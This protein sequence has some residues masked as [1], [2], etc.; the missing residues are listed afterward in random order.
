MAQPGRRVGK[1]RR[2]Q[3]HAAQALCV[4]RPEQA[5][6][7]QQRVDGRAH[8]ARGA[9]AGLAQ[10]LD[11]E[12]GELGGQQ[13]RQ[14]RPQVLRTRRRKE[15][16]L[17]KRHR[18]AGA[19]WPVPAQPRAQRLIHGELQPAGRR[20][21]GR[22]QRHA[23]AAHTGGV[24]GQRG[25]P[26]DPVERAALG[27]SADVHAPGRRQ[28]EA[29]VHGPGRDD[30]RVRHRCGCGDARGRRP[31]RAQGTEQ[32]RAARVVGHRSAQVCERVVQQVLERRGQ[33]AAGGV[34]QLQRTQQLAQGGQ[35]RGC[36]ALQGLQGRGD[37]QARLG[38]QRAG[39]V[40]AGRGQVGRQRAQVSGLQ[41][42]PLARHAEHLRIDQRGAGQRRCCGGVTAQGDV[43]VELEPAQLRWHR[44]AGSA[45]G[46]GA[47]HEP[48]V[49]AA[50]FKM[51]TQPARG[52][53]G[54]AGPG[55]LHTGE[56]DFGVAAQL[57]LASGGQR[58]LEH[59]PQRQAKAVGRGQLERQAPGVALG[60]AGGHHGREAAPHR[61][62]T[63]LAKHHVHREPGARCGGR[64][65][66]RAQL[67]GRVVLCG[68]LGECG[69]EPAAD[70][71]IGVVGDVVGV[72]GQQALQQA[73]RIGG[74]GD[75]DDRQR[76]RP[77]WRA[78][79][80][81]VGHH[82]HG[83]GR[84][85]RGMA[86]CRF[87]HQHHATRHAT[88]RGQHAGQT[89]GLAGQAV[90]VAAGQTAGR[91]PAERQEPLASGRRGHQRAD[92]QRRWRETRHREVDVPRCRH[93][94]PGRGARGGHGHAQHGDWRAAEQRV[95]FECFA[96]V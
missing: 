83:L 67:A 40:E 39:G 90:F 45:A 93:A 79:G 74:R 33:A 24:E 88:K 78:Q 86:C 37:E 5:H 55:H 22:A 12:P 34:K 41:A 53:E 10:R 94:G 70:V 46:V 63:D 69:D 38:D 23:A 56:V 95:Q 21:V 62:F 59:G 77:G 20:V 7:R 31:Q 49:A 1:Q 76:H 48:A 96:Q 71:Q 82:G 30:D 8:G 61:V 91:P 44:L 3:R 81:E 92:V 9:G 52:G 80:D 85:P 14:R 28:Y 60:Q 17:V 89:L 2:R 43:D 66:R 18:G 65:G 11:A 6:G 32:G 75:I 50:E 19:R 64:G 58:R 29:H 4:G 57:R 68:Q 25:L 47:A 87:G 84:A 36:G 16:Q 73:Q 13:P 42:P 54:H 15:F 26:R 35:G 72:A 51:H 27:R